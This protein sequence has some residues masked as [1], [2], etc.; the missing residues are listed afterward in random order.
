MKVRTNPAFTMIEILLVVGIIAFLFAFLGP[1]IYKM[2]AKSD[3]KITEL[4]MGKIKGAMIEY[5]QDMGHYPNK[6]E[7]LAALRSVPSTRGAS[8]KWDGPYLD[9]DDDL[10]DKWGNEFEYNIPPVK[11]KNKYRYFQIISLGSG[12]EGAKE[13]RTGA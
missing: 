8:E 4:K 9:E 13:L 3:I 7:G 12:E 1:R 11:Y 10:L 2:I 6:K 5:K